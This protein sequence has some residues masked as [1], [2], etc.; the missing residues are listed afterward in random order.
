MEPDVVLR[1]A[2]SHAELMESYG[3]RREVGIAC[4]WVSA[5]ASLHSSSVLR[6]VMGQIVPF[7]N[8]KHFKA[9]VVSVLRTL[10]GEMTTSDILVEPDEFE[11]FF[12]ASFDPKRRKD[13]ERFYPRIKV[14]N[15]CWW[16]VLS[17]LLHY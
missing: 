5:Q 8:Y 13:F 10:G 3:N 12:E 9:F 11:D 2:K 1:R 4:L 16:T 14:S 15:R 7:Y 6:I 17:F